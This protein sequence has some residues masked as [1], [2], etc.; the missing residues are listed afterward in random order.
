MNFFFIMKL[1]IFSKFI[2]L[3]LFAHGSAFAVETRFAYSDLI[4]N[5]LEELLQ[6]D[7]N[8]LENNFRAD[9]HNLSL[10]R[11]GTLPIIEDFL[12]DRLDIC[13]VA[14]PEG[15]DL[16]TL[17]I[18]NIVK[19][20]FAYKSAV[21]VVNS[22]NPI[23][24]ITL[25]QLSTIYGTSSASSNLLSWRDFGLSS[26]STST[27]KAY[28]VKESQ[29]IS[30]DLFRYSVLGEKAFNSSV[31]ID[32]QEDVKRLITQDK[33]AVGVFPNVPEDPNLKALFV[34]QDY[35]SIAYG[36]GADNI[37]YSDYPI[38][39]PFYIV[40]NIRDSERLYPLIQSLLSD[41]VANSI[42]NNN[43]F[44]LPKVIREKLVFDLKLY[45]QER[46]D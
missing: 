31:I 29:E 33:A 5:E 38:R 10:Y 16:P 42:A 11:S 26:F 14:M 28:A 44:S 8:S 24:E 22:E 43:F 23:S 1:S 7:I 40:Y 18:N 39:L 35:E 6:V 21:V 12:S 19:I 9:E 13:I 2:L 41:S 15:I 30:S 32:F 45:L 4:S 46:E 37:Y 36:P 17:D 20:P 3:C 34:A 25:D 27:I